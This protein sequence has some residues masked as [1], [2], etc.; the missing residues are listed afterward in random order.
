MKSNLAYLHE[1]EKGLQAS[2]TSRWLLMRK[3]TIDNKNRNI[4]VEIKRHKP[5]CS[6]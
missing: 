3:P 4:D 1:R 2:L 6:I 5:Q